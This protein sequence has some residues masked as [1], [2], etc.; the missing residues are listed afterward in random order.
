VC[1]SDYPEALRAGVHAA[2]ALAMAMAMSII[3]AM[4]CRLSGHV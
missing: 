3:V 2:M 1:V 4:I